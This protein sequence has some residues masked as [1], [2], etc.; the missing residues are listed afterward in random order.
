MILAAATMAL[1]T[2]CTI[3]IRPLHNFHAK[4]HAALNPGRPL[5][6]F[7]MIAFAAHAA[8]FAMMLA[9][10][11]AD[12]YTL[13]ELESISKSAGFARGELAPPEIGLDRLVI[14]Y[15]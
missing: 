13:P 2:I 5:N 3:S 6:S 14:A 9:H 7:P 1:I 4:V 15:R 11:A 12:V 10:P 8:A